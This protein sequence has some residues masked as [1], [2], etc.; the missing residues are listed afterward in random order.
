MSRKTFSWFLL[1]LLAFTVV[2]SAIPKPAHAETVYG[3]SDKA[4]AFCPLTTT[5]TGGNRDQPA[6]WL[7]LNFV[8]RARIELTYKGGGCPPDDKLVGALNFKD[9]LQTTFIDDNTSDGDFT[10]RA[11][12]GDAAKDDS[13]IHNFTI[14]SSGSKCNIKNDDPTGGRDQ[15]IDTNGFKECLSSNGGKNGVELVISI[16]ESKT[17]GYNCVKDAGG[18]NFVFLKDGGYKWVC[19][20]TAGTFAG[21]HTGANSTTN[22]DGLVVVNSF[23]NLDNY[24]ITYTYDAAKDTIT[25]VSEHEKEFRTFYWCPTTNNYTSGKNCKGDLSINNETKA[26]LSAISATS[27][28]KVTIQKSNGKSVDALVAGANSAAAQGPQSVGEIGSNAAP[29]GQDAQLNCEAVASGSVLGNAA[30]AGAEIA[31]GGAAGVVTHG[32]V[33]RLADQAISWI[34]CPIIDGAVAIINGVGNAVI[35]Q[36]IVNPHVLDYQNCGKKPDCA[37]GAVHSA[38][39]DFRIMSLSLLILVALVGIAASSFID[40]YTVKKILPRMLIAIVAITLSW[41]LLKLAL[42]VTNAVGIGVRALILAP[43]SG[44]PAPSIEPAGILA[45]VGGVGFV[46]GLL[47]M[48]SFVATAA[49]AVIMAFVFVAIRYVAII[50]LIIVAPLA[51]MSSILPG[52]Q[53]LWK[54]W[55][56]GL[57][58][59]LLMLPLVTGLLALGASLGKVVA[60]LQGG[61][62]GQMMALIV[63]FGPYF[64]IPKAFAMAGGLI[65]NLSGMVNDRGRGAFDRLKKFRQGEAHKAWDRKKTGNMFKSAP[66]DSFRGRLNK[67]MMGATMANELGFNPKR[68]K[69]NMTMA[70]GERESVQSEEIMKSPLG[71]MLQDD[72]IAS[73]LVDANG[74]EAAFR[75]ILQER[76]YKRFGGD[77]N[78]DALDLAT[79]GA[80]R[81]S[82]KYGSGEVRIAA[83]RSKF[84]SSTGW[85]NEWEYETEKDEEGNERLG[86]DG[87]AIFKTDANGDKIIAKDDQGN[88]KI[89]KYTASGDMLNDIN[90]VAGNNRILSTQLLAEARSGQTR[91]GREDT[92]GGGFSDTAVEMDKLH[93][94]DKV[95]YTD[96]KTGEIKE[97]VYNLEDATEKVTES[98]IKGKPIHEIFRSGKPAVARAV[99]PVM[100]KMTEA[101][102]LKAHQSADAADVRITQEAAREVTV[103]QNNATLGVEEKQQRVAAVQQRVTVSKQ[104]VQAQRDQQIIRTIAQEQMMHAVAASSSTE[105]AQVMGD[106]VFSKPF[107]MDQLPQAI[108][109]KI[110]K[111]SGPNPTRGQAYEALRD[112]PVWGAYVKEY[113]RISGGGRLITDGEVAERQAIDGVEAAVA[114]SRIEADRR[115]EQEA[116]DRARIAAGG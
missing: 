50:A 58:G 77:E 24:N 10:Y 4:S 61:P 15:I 54:I 8:S 67:G 18:S 80:M 91:A 93:R 27:P 83:L 56:E 60:Q 53:K 84:N 36:L 116:A 98:L 106:K 64:V 65:S 62:F 44:L 74:D 23:N 63:T 82:R 55:H 96:E 95:T 78:K 26:S 69:E 72:D 7:E 14:N 5:T 68:W 16:E 25:H 81:I 6:G 12:S 94:K 79:A 1:L 34:L 85:N 33:G 51:I 59:A 102:I 104:R 29:S 48:L 114:R 109:D 22:F 99:A 38:W 3:D 46:F 108:R 103:I 75:R 57:S 19:V 113:G 90:K 66:E 107:P 76:A 70:M 47:G 41:D 40:A 88:N 35:D 111:Q 20:Q 112:D 105:A 13:V 11:K 87:K 30:G 43:F 110:E 71:R 45:G 9:L 100:L 92:G 52:T 42:G 115:G 39:N 2:F 21:K 49:L 32:A 31:T 89:W 28:K 73:A 86:A 17:P 97:R 101:G 37:G